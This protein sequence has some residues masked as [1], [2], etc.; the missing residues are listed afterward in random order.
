MPNQSQE[1]DK[2]IQRIKKLLSMAEDVS[3]PNEAMIAARRARS[4]M[5]KHQITKDDIATTEDNQFLESIAKRQTSVRKQWL[6]NLWSAAGMLNDCEPVVSG[7]PF[8]KYMFR[9]FKAD[10]IVAKL[11]MDYLVE[12]CDRCCAKSTAFGLSEKNFF[13]LGFSEAVQE[14]VREI[15]KERAKLKTSKGKG[16]IVSKHDSI[17]AHFGD[18]PTLKQ[19]ETREPTYDELEAYEDGWENGNK[20]GLDKQVTA[21]TRKA[22]ACA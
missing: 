15:L 21:D 17:V 5:D 13:R 18:L 9:G 7:S 19:R 11:T 16:L 12:T 20:V 6:L 2:I 22:I 14:R 8:V 3:S 10:S 4:L 1:Q